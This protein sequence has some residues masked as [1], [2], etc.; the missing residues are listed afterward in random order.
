VDGVWKI[1]SKDIMGWAGAV[2][3]RFG[4]R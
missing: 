4:A 2:L 3:A 1:C